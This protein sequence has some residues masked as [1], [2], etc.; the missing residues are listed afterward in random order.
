MIGYKLL[1]Y[2]LFTK[3]DH[4]HHGWTNLHFYYYDYSITV[5]FSA[6]NGLSVLKI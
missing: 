2:K 1:Y 5:D 3:F 4:V 6:P